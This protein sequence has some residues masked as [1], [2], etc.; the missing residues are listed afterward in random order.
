MATCHNGLFRC[1]TPWRLGARPRARIPAVRAAP[2]CLSRGAGPPTAGPYGG[3]EPRGPRDGFETPGLEVTPLVP[4]PCRWLELVTAHGSRAWRSS[5]LRAG[6][7][8]TAVSS[9]ARGP[10]PAVRTLQDSQTP[11]VHDGVPSAWSP[12]PSLPAGGSGPQIISALRFG[13]TGPGASGG[14]SPPNPGHP[15]ARPILGSARESTWREA[16]RES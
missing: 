14:K 12:R 16:P 5:G 9:H 6:G 15:Q 2:R 7:L 3:G 1:H 4:L 10:D 13:A 8:G 11:D